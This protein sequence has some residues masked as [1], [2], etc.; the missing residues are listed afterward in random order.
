M[1]EKKKE[2]RWKESNKGMIRG[3]VMGREYDEILAF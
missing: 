1:E 2:E 3:N